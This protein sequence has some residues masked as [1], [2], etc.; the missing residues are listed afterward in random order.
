MP[1]ISSKPFIFSCFALSVDGRLCYPDLKSGFTIANKN[2]RANYNEQ[3]A[4]W[5]C[6]SLARTIS[7]AVIIGSN[8]LLYEEY[9]YQAKLDINEL[10]IS[11]Q[12]L[13]KPKNLLHILISRNISKINLD[14]ELICQ[15]ADTP[16]L[17]YTNNLPDNLPDNFSQS[18]LKNL[19]L[20]PLKQ[21]ITTSG[22]LDISKL[23]TKLHTLGINTILNES[24]YYHHQLQQLRLLDETWLN[25]SGVYIGGNV[26][27]LGQYNPSF[28][29]I[30][31][32]HYS[33]LSVHHIAFN[34]LYT[35]YKIEYTNAT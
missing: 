22:K 4:D 14:M 9:N 25:T 34:F 21:V 33:I 29:S 23:I 8:S 3:Y 6:L 11:R 2:F 5:W 12:K 30:N 31:H 1:K 20:A 27:T 13:N 35:R 15:D 17:I 10:I 16:L 32:P 18:E 19:S 24:P 26:A 28:S 7:D